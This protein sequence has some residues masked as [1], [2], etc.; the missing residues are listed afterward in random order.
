MQDRV[1]NR[2]V[3]TKLIADNAPMYIGWELTKYLRDLFLPL[4]Q[5]ETKHQHQ[6]PAE[7][8]YETVKC[9]TNRTMGRSGTPPAA[10]SYVWYISTSVSIT[11]LIQTLVMEPNIL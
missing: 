6:N 8:R 9:H 11:V 3:P 2:S 4:W 7:N 1:R 5:C 10:C